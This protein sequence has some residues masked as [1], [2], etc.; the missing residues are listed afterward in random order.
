[1]TC[2]DTLKPHK[3]KQRRYRSARLSH[4][5]MCRALSCDSHSKSSSVTPR[6]N[7]VDA[8]PNPSKEQLLEIVQRHFMS[9]EMD[10]LQVIMG[11]VQAAK[12]MKKACWWKSREHQNTMNLTATS[13]ALRWTNRRVHIFKPWH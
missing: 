7:M 1:M 5:A 12:G 8:L 13:R 11:F 2:E 6:V 4:K 3:S 9:Q 10:E